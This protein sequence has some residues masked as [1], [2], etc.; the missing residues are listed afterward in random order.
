[1]IIEL[2]I[3]YLRGREYKNSISGNDRFIH[4]LSQ[5]KS[6]NFLFKMIKNLYTSICKAECINFL[7]LFIRK[8][9]IPRLREG[10]CEF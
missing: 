9:F 5:K 6:V 4:F 7:F 3:S 1:M 2:I 8:I 10:E